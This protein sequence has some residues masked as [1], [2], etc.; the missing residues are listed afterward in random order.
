MNRRALL[1]TTAVG[2]SLLAGCATDETGDETV[3]LTELRVLNRDSTDRLV[4]L[5]V[6][7]DGAVETWTTV[8]VEAYD[9]ATDQ[10]GGVTVDQS[11]P[12][13][14]ADVE[15]Y[16]R[17]GE[18]DWRSLSVADSTATN[19]AEVIVVAEDRTVRVFSGDVSE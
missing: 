8:G 9:K 16:A 7:F 12:D 5:L 10:A 14:A 4:Y 3:R 17:I 13:T 11:W 18:N 15:V 2:L 6:L 1:S 19:T